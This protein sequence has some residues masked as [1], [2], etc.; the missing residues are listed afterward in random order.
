[1]IVL[2]VDD[3]LTVSLSLSL[4][5]GADIKNICNEAALV[6]ARHEKTSI[7]HTDFDYAMERV[8]AGVARKSRVLSPQELRVVAYHEAGHALVGWLLEHTDALL[9]VTIKSRT[10]SIL[11]FAQYAP[12]ERR[13]ISKEEVRTTGTCTF[14]TIHAH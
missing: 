4:S 10:S 7:D 3:A 5:A 6:A 14:V 12:T 11:G 8:I 9:K 1:M 2:R 13:L